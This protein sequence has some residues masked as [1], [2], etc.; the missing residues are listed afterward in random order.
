MFCFVVL[1]WVF[2]INSYFYEMKYLSLLFI[3]IAF[4]VHKCL[5]ECI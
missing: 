1:M 3:G 2:V 4:V 5:K